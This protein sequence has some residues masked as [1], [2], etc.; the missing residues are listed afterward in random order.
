MLIALVPSGK[1]FTPSG[2][3]IPELKNGIL[4]LGTSQG[5]EIVP[6]RDVPFRK[7]KKPEG[8]S[9]PLPDADL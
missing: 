4:N 1:H 8:Y 5:R 7:K 9:R 6:V 2:S 3:P